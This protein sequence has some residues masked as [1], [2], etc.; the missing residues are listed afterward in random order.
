MTGEITLRGRVMGIGGLKE[1]VLGA[2]RAGIR[3]VIA[4]AENRTDAVK[5][6]KDILRD[7]HMVWVTHMDEVI[8]AALVFDT[9][10]V[11]PLTDAV[12]APVP[13]D[14]VIP[15][16]PRRIEITQDIAIVSDEPQ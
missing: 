12:I 13:V 8:A 14:E 16:E 1:K 5:I 10:P 11:L 7:M 3:T 2:H 15:L 9:P 4:P 6:P